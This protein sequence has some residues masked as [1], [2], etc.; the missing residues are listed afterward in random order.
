MTLMFLC[1]FGKGTTPLGIPVELLVLSIIPQTGDDE[2]AY[3]TFV[4]E[5]PDFMKPSRTVMKIEDMDKSND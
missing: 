1:E 2:K 3:R 5:L 4:S